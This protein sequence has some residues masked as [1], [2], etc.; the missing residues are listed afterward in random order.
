[1][2]MIA[3]KDFE[4]IWAYKYVRFADGRVMFCDACDTGSSHKQ[5]VDEYRHA[6]MRGDPLGGQQIPPVSAGQ[7]KVRHGG[8]AITEGGSTTA[9]LRRCESDE[10]YIAK[11]LGRKFYHDITVS[12]H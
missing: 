8:W 10:K 7:I 11:E 1:M 3:P 6:I 9:K 12:Y 5:I 2:R 4:D